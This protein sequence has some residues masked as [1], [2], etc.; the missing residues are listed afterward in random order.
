[1]SPVSPTVW[2]TSTPTL[3]AAL[4]SSGRTTFIGSV[5]LSRFVDGGGIKRGVGFGEA[6]GSPTPQP[7]QGQINANRLSANRRLALI[8]LLDPSG[9][10]RRYFVVS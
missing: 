2:N 7:N 9:E 5:K 3:T 6:T 10:V 1:M 4:A 8:L